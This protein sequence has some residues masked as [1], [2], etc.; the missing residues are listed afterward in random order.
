MAPPGVSNP[1]QPNP[2]RRRRCASPANSPAPSRRPS[3]RTRTKRSPARTRRGCTEARSISTP[4][5]ERRRRTGRKRYREKPRSD[6][7]LERQ[8]LHGATARGADVERPRAVAAP[9]L[10]DQHRGEAR[11]APPPT[12]L[13][14]LHLPSTPRPPSSSSPSCSRTRQV[15]EVISSCAKGL[16]RT[17]AR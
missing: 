2:T 9:L 8:P 3:D 13:H 7:I 14:L 11:S 17:P 10:H 6:V 4:S 1:T 5:R 12:L 15:G 16:S